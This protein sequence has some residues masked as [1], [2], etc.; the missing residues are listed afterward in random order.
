MAEFKL[1]SNFF[2]VNIGSWEPFVE[3]FNCEVMIEQSVEKQSMKIYFSN[4]VN[5]NFTEKLI[6]NLNESQKSWNICFTDYK[7]FE[8]ITET[9]F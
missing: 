6:E 2:N 4:A 3:K 7:K 1:S 5:F 8:T 9:D